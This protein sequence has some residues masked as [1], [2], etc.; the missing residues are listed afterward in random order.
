M[1]RAESMTKA[2]TPKTHRVKCR[3]GRVA[4]HVEFTAESLARLAAARVLDLFARQQGQ[5][6]AT[7]A[8]RDLLKPS[9]TM[10]E[11]ASSLAKWMRGYRARRR[12]LVSG[13]E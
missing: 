13:K 9:L 8:V 7:Q 1:A 6:L 2:P 11:F 12:P 3:G 5:H 4:G 10:E